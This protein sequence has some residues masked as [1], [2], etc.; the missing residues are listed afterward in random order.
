MTLSVAAHAQATGNRPLLRDSFRIGSEGGALCQAQSATGDP[1]ARTMFDRAWTLVCR[2]AARPVGQIYA[3]RR[4]AA[5]DDGALQDRLAA[6][7]REAVECNAPGGV[8][9]PGIGLALM[10]NCAGAVG[11][12]RILAVERGKTIYV[13]QGYAAYASALDLGL[14]SVMA[15]RIVP[16]RVDIATVG[17]NDAGYARLQAATLDPQTVL[18]EGYRRNASGNYAEAAEFFDSLTD[19]LARDPDAAKLTPAERANRA[20][21]YL[22]N[23][24]L[25]L[26]NLGL[27][28]QA[29]A[30]F[31]EAR[32]IVTADAVQVRLRRNFEAMH[33]INR[34][35]SAGA[36]AILDR[37]LTSGATASAGGDGAVSLPPE[38]AA[39]MSSGAAQARALGVRQDNML[40]PVERS[41]ILDA[42]AQQLRGT[43]L[44]L[45]GQPGP[46]REVLTKALASAVAIRDGR[47][48]SITRLRAQL[49][50]EIALTHEVQADYGQAERQ[51]NQA[52]A[53]LGA[54]Y[55]ETV[56]LNGARARLGA[57]LIR[58]DRNEDALK[59]YR[60]IIASTMQNRATLTGMANQLQPYFNLLAREIPTRPEL[61]A[62]LF[63]ASQT[64]LR[65]GAADTLEQLSRE[66]SAGDGEAARLFRQSVSLSRDIER[67]R[68]ALAQLRQAA[69]G[70][71][72]LL[73]DVAQAQADIDQLAAD[74]A[75][76][77]AALAAYP[78]Y[79]ALSPQGLTLAEMQATLKPGEG[80]YKLAQLGD[81][82]YALWIDGAGATGYRLA[83]SAT[84]VAR[85][86]A[87][88][89]ETISIN[90]NG[91]QTTY[92][93]D[94]P[95]ARSLYLDLFRPVEQR[96]AAARHLIFE[97]DGAMLQLPVNL[98]VAG[99]AGVD[100]YE[101]R[102]AQGGDEFDFRGI[103]WL[104]RDHAVSTALSAR[105]FRDAR[106][107]APSGAAQSYI[108]FGDNAP[109]AGPVLAASSRG[110]L[111]SG[112]AD[113]C[114]WSPLQ[115]N[116]P[117]PA[118]ELREA[119]Q[120][121]GG[122][123][124][125]LI[126]GAAFTDEA[127]M[128]R[129]DL[130][131]FRILHFAT[132][133]LVTP[134]HPGCPA[135]PALLTSFAP[136]RK[137]DGLLQFSEIFD[138]RLNADLVVLSACDTAGAAGAETTRAAGLSGG[139]GA[140]DGLVRAFIG[141]GSR[142]VIASH[143][144][145][146]EDYRATER[147]MGGLFAAPADQPMAEAL[148]AAQARLMDD[149]ETSHPFYWSGFA[150][151][152]DGARPLIARR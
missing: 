125:E 102:V 62:D 59:I 17:T 148:R 55:P 117:I 110:G 61:T 25:Q 81:A 83:A 120:A 9:L 142:A 97:P 30:A 78:Q 144:P 36:L 52:L 10:R 2:D 111:T 68:I 74:Q 140:L 149:A 76:T 39:E 112:A 5:T 51:L 7:R 103:D 100:A 31:A 21:E 42:Q 65:P 56:A 101:A 4:G 116:R 18:A 141:A 91:V 109:L 132:H 152:G 71:E 37:P 13:A 137:S 113:D 150:I 38:V 119:A 73:P 60:G 138:L 15:G 134:P 14:R 1:A 29:E 145:A 139:G 89:R 98:L 54:Q 66:L 11:A 90:V 58:R 135:R 146:P 80:Y 95:A 104:G 99:Q 28:D 22:V 34:Q 33:H 151:I 79:R 130:D 72:A 40:T 84:D 85:K 8:T 96:L 32:R 24:G 26:S 77:L 136:D 19:R 6:S 50:G 3:L 87:A 75:H 115:W 27:F 131:R 46:A 93:L 126:T 49:L 48:T 128:A 16:G 35:D 118:T 41:A 57:F 127:V 69:Q 53:L 105:A 129:G 124:N 133:G 147:L 12:Y 88:L 114:G 86:V 20:H 43:I 70:R 64:L 122:L 47:V 123:G 82:L 44:R 121:I 92:A 94:V 106:A 63:A 23:R 108:G 143:W 67:G 107:A 45:S